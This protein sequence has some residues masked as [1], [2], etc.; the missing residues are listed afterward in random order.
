MTIID[1]LRELE[2]K[3]TPEKWDADDGC[4][5]EILAQDPDL[6]GTL[7]V[8]GA[9]GC[10]DDTDLAVAMRNALPALLRV[11]KAADRVREV[12]SWGK[13]PRQVHA[14]EAWQELDAALSALEVD[15]G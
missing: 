1:K 15:N 3:A 9:M 6:P 8:I 14:G 7:V 5:H 4:G 11:A 10:P 12:R 2:A 13:V